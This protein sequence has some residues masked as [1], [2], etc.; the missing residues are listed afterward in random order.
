VRVVDY[1]RLAR[2]NVSIKP[3][4]PQRL[5]GNAQNQALDGVCSNEYRRTMEQ[6]MRVASPAS[7]RRPMLR[8]LP[9]PP[10]TEPQ[11]QPGEPSP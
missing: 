3:R 7:R 2:V 1:L 6:G 11:S 4:W 10:I 8:L 5:L 9:L